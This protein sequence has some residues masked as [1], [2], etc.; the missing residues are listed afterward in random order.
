[1]T[2]EEFERTKEFILQQQAQFATDIQQLRE[3]QA[4]TESIVARLAHGTLEGFKDVNAKINA[5]VDS[6]IHTDERIKALADVQKQTAEDLR[7]LIAVA[8]RY[9]SEGRDGS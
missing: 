2:N 6:Q 4:Q 8:D 1:M 7:N 9:F 5:L 3:V